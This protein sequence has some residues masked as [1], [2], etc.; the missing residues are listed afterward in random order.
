MK[1]IMWKCTECGE[2]FEA[3]E[4]HDCRVDSIEAELEKARREAMRKTNPR[5]DRRKRDKALAKWKADRR[6]KR[7]GK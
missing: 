7:A 1:P 4:G 5:P 6:G 2:K 3:V